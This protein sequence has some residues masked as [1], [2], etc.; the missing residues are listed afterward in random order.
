MDFGMV[1][2]MMIESQNDGEEY[3]ELADERDFMDF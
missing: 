2:E 1:R 3:F